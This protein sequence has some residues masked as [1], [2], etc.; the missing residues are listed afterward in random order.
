[1]DN[2]QIEKKRAEFKVRLTI[3]KENLSNIKTQLDK[4][5]IDLNEISSKYTSGIKIEEAKSYQLNALETDLKKELKTFEGLRVY[6]KNLQREKEN[7]ESENAFYIN[8]ISQLKSK[9]CELSQVLS[10][11]K[12]KKHLLTVEINQLSNENSSYK[13][14]MYDHDKLQYT[15]KNQHEYVTNSINANNKK[16]QLL[17]IKIDSLNKDVKANEEELSKAKEY[18]DKCDLYNKDILPKIITLKETNKGYDVKMNLVQNEIEETKDYIDST[19][20]EKKKLVK[21]MNQ[22][23]NI[24]AELNMTNVRINSCLGIMVNS[25][26]KKADYFQKDKEYFDGCLKEKGRFVKILRDISSYKDLI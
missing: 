26:E 24:L 21:Q 5:S 20:K 18:N 3:L 25:L 22:L 14:V 2:I 4:S 6:C 7:S 15:T 12:N 23:S 11:M 13:K 1:M 9:N 17:Q 10:E 8:K 19:K 16:I